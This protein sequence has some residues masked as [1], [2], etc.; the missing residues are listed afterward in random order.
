LHTL[1]VAAGE[2]G[3]L[4]RAPDGKWDRYA[5]GELTPTPFAAPD[6]FLSVFYTW[7]ELVTLGL[8]AGAVFFVL[9]I[10][11]AIAQTRKRMP[12]RQ[13]TLLSGLCMLLIVLVGFLPIALWAV[14]TIPGYDLAEKL[15]WIG[16]GIM[17]ALTFVPLGIGILRARHP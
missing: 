9:A 5:V 6:I 14:G 1:I 16:A 15:M 10:V 17:S 13:A 8:V 4:V 2:Q 11:L 3:V 12:S 7:G